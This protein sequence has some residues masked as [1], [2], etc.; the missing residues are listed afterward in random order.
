MIPLSLGTIS[1]LFLILA[2]LGILAGFIGLDIAG[3]RERLR[4]R[5]AGVSGEVRGPSMGAAPGA[6]IAVRLQA[7][8]RS[9]LASPLLG[10]AE[11][12]KLAG[13]LANCGL[14]DPN[15]LTMFVCVKFG[16][17]IILP[18]LTWIGLS[19]IGFWPSTVLGQM[20]LILG[21]TLAGWRGPDVWVNRRIN[22]WRLVLADSLPDALDLLVICTD[23]G[24]G[25]EQALDRVAH[26]LA[27][28][29]PVL[30]AE[31]QLTLAEM[32]VL[33]QIRDAL[34]NLATRTQSRPIQLLVGT[35]VQ[36]LQYGT[37]L[38]QSL[39]TLSAEMHVHRFLQYEANAAKLPVML[40]LPMVIFILPTMFLV[41]CGPAALQVIDTIKTL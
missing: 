16:L 8:G 10:A 26:D 32:R 7:V 23:A 18:V 40:T 25:L 39:R 21:S 31:L 17:T 13:K 9:L 30:A 29:R 1:I 36:T 27:P 24:L 38:G 12:E 15:A 11:R 28:S 41:V 19:Y 20:P 14:R 2:G 22:E 37:P 5:V 33:P 4:M 3:R 34:T 35:L 6:A